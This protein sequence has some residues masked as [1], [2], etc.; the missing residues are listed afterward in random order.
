MGITYYRV[1]SDAIYLDDDTGFLNERGILRVRN[2]FVPYDDM[3]P[4]IYDSYSSFAGEYYRYA[5]D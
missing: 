3:L 2:G 1:F 5:I 4:G